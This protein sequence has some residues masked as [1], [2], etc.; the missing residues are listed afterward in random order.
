MSRS[1]LLATVR[2]IVCRIALA[3]PGLRSY[4]TGL[5]YLPQPVYTEFALRTRGKMPGLGT[6]LPQPR[7]A[8]PDVTEVLLDEVLSSGFNL[9]GVNVGTADWERVRREAPSLQCNAVDVVL[10]DRRALTGTAITQV[11][12]SDG[13]LESLLGRFDGKFL[14]VRPDRYICASFDAAEA[15]DVQAAIGTHFVDLIDDISTTRQS[16][17]NI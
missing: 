8:L 7:V 16:T 5:R 13:H 3:T 12:D 6:Q 4:L 9:L 14:L 11:S 10:G 2:D 15:A 1:R 17:A